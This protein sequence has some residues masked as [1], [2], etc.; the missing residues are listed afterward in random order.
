MSKR[1]RRKKFEG[2]VIDSK[3]TDMDTLED[4]FYNMYKDDDPELQKED[5]DHAI[6]REIQ[7]AK[8]L[9]QGI[10]LPELPEETLEEEEDDGMSGHKFFLDANSGKVMELNEQQPGVQQAPTV[11]Q[12]QQASEEEWYFDQDVMQWKTWPFVSQE[13][14]DSGSTAVIEEAEFT[15]QDKDEYYF[16]ND[17]MK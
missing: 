4:Y 9:K 8:M 5:K 7:E 14:Q 11:F 3:G 10:K 15:E 2:V 12:E 6:H 16:D 13:Q 1:L 17:D